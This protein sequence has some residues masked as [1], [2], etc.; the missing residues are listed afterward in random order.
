M[1][2]LLLTILLLSNFIYANI[3]DT[4]PQL[5]GRVVDN[6]ILL[7]TA[8][9]E[10]ISLILQKHEDETSNQIVVVTLKSL[11][12]Y[13]IEDYSYQLGRHWGI[14]QKD[15]NNGVLLVISLEDR[16]LRIEVGYGLEGALT[17]KIS[18]EIIEYVLKPKFRKKQYNLGIQN[19][20]NEI[21][22]AIKGEYVPST[23][24]QQIVD[25]EEMLPILFFGI[26]FLSMMMNNISK[27]TKNAL[28]YKVSKSSLS[29]SFTAVFTYVFSAAFTSYALILAFGIFA[30]VFGI[31]FFKNKI[32]DFDKIKRDSR[33][34]A[35]AFG[36]LASGA[37]FSSFGGGGFSGGGG[38]F[39]GGGASGGW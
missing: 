7:S 10:N 28:L 6:A 11:E 18:H 32:I 39:G 20:V 2:K 15:K 22:T 29:G 8:Q 27:S 21:I 30:L 31:S 38:G 36:T 35:A 9:K 1:K 5:T 4:F 13:E 19:A 33:S 17:D 3:T 37:G 16:K 23:Q 25:S 34:N 12:G 24:N 14:G 26:I